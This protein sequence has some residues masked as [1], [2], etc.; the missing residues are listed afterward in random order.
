MQSGDE[1][2]ANNDILN[3]NFNSVG[4]ALLGV[5]SGNGNQG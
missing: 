4:T 1:T 3:N 5:A 2:T